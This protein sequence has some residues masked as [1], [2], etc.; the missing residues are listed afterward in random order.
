MR[1]VAQSV[2]TNQWKGQ[3]MSRNTLNLTSQVYEY[4]LQVS[5][6]ESPLLASLRQ[7]TLN[8]PESNMQIAPEQGQF[9][10]LLVKLLNAKYLLE[11]GTFT[12]YSALAVAEALPDDGHITCCDVSE[13][14]TSIAQR[15][16]EKSGLK[17]K[18][19]LKLQPALDTLEGLLAEG[20]EEKYDMAFIDADKGNYLNYYEKCLQLI[21]SGGVILIDNVLWN[22]AV[23]DSNNQ[24]EDTLAIR[25]LNEH[26]HTDNRVDLSLVPI[27]DGLTLVR[28]K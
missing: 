4:L 27:G 6:R 11:V 8:L 2:T 9:M 16:W 19:M 10:S 3:F 17:H 7:E 22:G 24:E 1:M 5:L 12:G 18:F 21:R 28:K 23:A 26:L 14:F 15:Y 20:Q 13:E 25:A